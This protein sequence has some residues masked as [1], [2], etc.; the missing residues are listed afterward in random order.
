M[1]SPTKHSSPDDLDRL[2]SHALIR[3]PGFEEIHLRDL[4]RDQTVVIQFIR[5]FNCLVCRQN[6]IEFSQIVPLLQSQGV[7]PI[8]ICFGKAG[9]DEFLQGNFFNGEVFVDAKK[10]QLTAHGFKNYNLLQLW[11]TTGWDGVKE[12]RKKTTVG[13][14]VTK[15]D[16][17]GFQCGGTLIVE[18]GGEGIIM[19]QKQERLGDY[20][21]NTRILR[22]L[23][24]PIPKG[25]DKPPPVY[26][27]RRKLSTI[28]DDVN[29]NIGAHNEVHEGTGP[30][31]DQLDNYSIC[32]TIS[33]SINE[34]EKPEVRLPHGLDTDDLPFKIHHWDTNLHLDK[35]GLKVNDFVD[36]DQETLFSATS[37]SSTSAAP[38]S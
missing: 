6:A 11:W 30:T 3:V 28:P 15:A 20:V 8:L 13:R 9:L 34:G 27:G 25:L 35:A 22:S 31:Q 7:R 17:E 16:H 24:I 37:T 19:S 5:R 18:R 1:A 36:P 26:V 12:C 29:D 14:P 4:Y 38:A 10:E 23:D 32:S 21:N 33:G 2:G